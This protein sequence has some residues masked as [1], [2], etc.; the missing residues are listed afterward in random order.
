MQSKPVQV[1]LKTVAKDINTVKNTYS[2]AEY[3]EDNYAV[4]NYFK[5]YDSVVETHIKE[6]PNLENQLEFKIYFSNLPEGKGIGAEVFLY[7]ETHDLI[8]TPG[9]LRYD[10]EDEVGDLLESGEANVVDL[11]SWESAKFFQ[12]S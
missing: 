4:M 5:L 1:Q 11:S 12:K 8:T 9:D 3:Y 6:I 7:D 10:T 2:N